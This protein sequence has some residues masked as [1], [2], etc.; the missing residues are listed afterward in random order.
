MK[1]FTLV[2]CGLVLGVTT[3]SYVAGTLLQGQQPT[4][5]TVIPKELSS[6]RDIVK[7]VLPAVVSIDSRVKPSHQPA[8][9]R[10]SPMEDQIPEEF[11]RFFQFPQGDDESPAPTPRGGFGSGFIVDPKG[12]I[13]TNNHVVDGADSVIV[14][15][16][17]GR[18]YTS[19]DIKTDPKTDL[20]IVRID[21]KSPL[22]Y[23]EMGDSSSME[24]G[25]RVLAVGAPFGLTGTVTHGIISGKG[26]SVQINM[27]EDFLQ[28]DAAINPGNSGGPLVNLEGRVIGINAA[29][30]SRSGGF[31]GVGLAVSSN[32]AKNVM[33]QLLRSGVVHRGYLG[34]QIRDL[35]DPDLASRLGLKEGE[36]GVLVTRVFPKTPGA[37]AGL[38]EGDVIETLADKPVNDSHDL[39]TAVASLP[40]GKPVQLHVLRDGQPRTL[41]V[42]IEEQPRD[43]GTVRVQQSRGAQDAETVT[44][45]KIGV[46]AAD[47]TPEMVES[48][49][50]EE[51]TKG[52]LIAKVDSSGL[53][54]D[55]GLR[56]GMVISKV[57]KTPIT[58]AEGLKKA[59]DKASLGQGV[60]LQVQSVQGGKN[61]V[62]LK[63]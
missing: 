36:H 20:A 49:G 38:Q 55:A 21:A 27:Y 22:P 31:Q 54:A 1:R 26:R 11:R 59:L 18:K 5:A 17:D 44:I 45:D 30:K 9:R 32:L 7:H 56:R 53:A 52:A 4:T 13:L 25:D 40:L 61:F 42:T 43:Y 29:I 35:S 2:A 8:S 41:S 19:H 24:I 6:Y 57:D 28:T 63:K 12:V 10:R 33:E 60:L 48:L 15:L 14:E 62:L 34:V 51:G 37:K 46:E 3:G 16:H 39:Q 47:L 58:S 50:F 23:L